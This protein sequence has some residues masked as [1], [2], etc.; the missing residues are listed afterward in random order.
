MTYSQAMEGSAESRLPRALAEGGAV[1]F[2]S[3]VLATAIA[4]GYHAFAIRSVGTRYSQENA[5][6]VTAVLL[7]A[8]FAWLITCLYIL[9]VRRNGLLLE[10]GIAIFGMLLTFFL[11][12]ALSMAN[13]CHVGGAFPLDVSC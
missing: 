10:A 1:A 2:G 5:E 3:I 11:A 13:E 4:F 7:S 8:W 9:R 12:G 6:M